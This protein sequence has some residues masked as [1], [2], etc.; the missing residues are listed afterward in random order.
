M[1]VKKKI[2]ISILGISAICM[3]LN[4]VKS[5]AALQSNGNSPATK[6]V[7]DWITGVRQMQVTGGTLGLT[8]EINA[9][10]LTS[11]N[12]NLDIH[13]QKNTE[14]GAMA[15]LSAS[16]YGNPD[17]I[18][19]GG[20]TTG[21]A[22]GIVI[23]L[24]GEW[25]ASG[26][27]NTIAT[28]MKNA[29]GRYKDVY[30]TNIDSAKS[31]DATETVG[32]WHESKQYTWISCMKWNCCDGTTAAYR[33][34]LLRGQGESIFSYYGRGIYLN[35]TS[36]NWNCNDHYTSSQMNYRV[37]Y[38]IADYSKVHGTRAVVVVGSGI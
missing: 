11:T 5:K 13:M 9:T 4:P 29:S 20:T 18:E 7:N 17:K 3:I 36:L 12:K 15:I 14:Y 27:S 31:G 28:S 19:D 32:T 6:N 25:T 16:S 37:S 38:D 24:N 10:N 21:N 35:N 26:T 33:S 1:E 34:V 2:L 23:K 8:D 22:T 30:T